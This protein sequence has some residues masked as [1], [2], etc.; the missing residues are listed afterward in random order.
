[1]SCC[2][3]IPDHKDM[4]AEQHIASVKRPYITCITTGQDIVSGLMSRGKW[5][6]GSIMVEKVY[7]RCKQKDLVVHKC[8]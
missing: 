5:L 4:S 1:M 6:K 7:G 3:D 2:C 8:V